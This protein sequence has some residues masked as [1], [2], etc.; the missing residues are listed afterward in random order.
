VTL[1]MALYI[2][3][4][5]V[6]AAVLLALLVVTWRSRSDPVAPWFAATLVAFLVWTVGYI[7]EIVAPSLGAK[8]WWADLE[9]IGIAVLPVAWFEVVRRYTGHGPLPRWFAALLGAF[10][11]VSVAVFAANP[12]HIFRVAP[13]LDTTTSPSVVVPD[14]GWFWAAF[15]MPVVYLL[16][17]TTVVL[18]GHAMWRDRQSLYRLQYGLLIVAILLP[19]VA[20]TLYIFG[21]EPAPGLNPTTAVVSVSGSIMAYAL[22]RYR[23]FGIA[24]L[25]RGMVVDGLSDGVIVLDTYDRIV[26]F[27]PAARHLFPDLDGEA[28]GR[29]VSEIL[30]FH[31]GLL[32]SIGHADDSAPDTVV[33]ELSMAL[34]GDA[35]GGD[36]PE[37]RHFTLA[38]TAVRTR[39]G[40][41]LGHSVLLHDVTHSVELL[42]QV[43]RLATTDPLTELLT[44]KAFLELG[45]REMT[46]ARRQGFPM[47]LVKLDLDHFTLVNDLYGSDA[48]DEVIRAVAGACRRLLRAF[49]LVGR[50]RGEEFVILL[51]HLSA[52]EAEEIAER[53]RQA[54]EALAVWKDDQLVTVTASVG[55]AGTEH[56][57][58]EFLN[59]LLA[60]ADST[61]RRAQEEGGNRVAFGAEEWGVAGPNGRAEQPGG[62][63]GP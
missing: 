50:F 17:G 27:N 52:D 37:S 53:L 13:R 7:L 59:D 25:A 16:L 8:L 1:H 56:A 35:A 43:E 54:V 4:L 38:L 33:A 57:D 62:E 45:E 31:P 34:P 24:P 49:D 18:L 23:L 6:S 26:D 10:V 2:T 29:P 11:A 60:P 55:L 47:W 40:R 41:V 5:V 30:A 48:G 42:R 51:P 61:L 21:L 44:R 3:P 46:R 36:L 14:Y 32:E 58:H 19:V 15:F 20:G 9:F 28:L 22:F 63:Q 39:G 12:G